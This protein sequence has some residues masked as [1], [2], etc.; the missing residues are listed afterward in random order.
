M[1]PRQAQGT[2]QGTIDEILLPQLPNRL[3]GHG[4]AENNLHFDSQHSTS[5]PLTGWVS[6]VSC[7]SSPSTTPSAKNVIDLV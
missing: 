3:R 6:I 1:L 5:P 7:V 2:G 4:H